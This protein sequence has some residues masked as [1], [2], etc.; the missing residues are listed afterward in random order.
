MV[1]RSLVLISLTILAL[2]VLQATGNFVRI[3]VTINLYSSIMPTIQLLCSFLFAYRLRKPLC[4]KLHGAVWK[5]ARLCQL[6]GRF[7]RP[8]T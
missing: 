4:S 3:R 1:P 6:L 7:M 8:T 2:G 5:H